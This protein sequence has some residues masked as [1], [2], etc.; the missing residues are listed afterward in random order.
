M[1]DFEVIN[2]HG[3]GNATA[4]EPKDFFRVDQRQWLLQPAVALAL[5]RR[6]SDVTFGP[7]GAALGHQP[8][9]AIH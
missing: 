7:V 8:P 5:G 3:V 4:R 6:E 2:F 1:S 9:G